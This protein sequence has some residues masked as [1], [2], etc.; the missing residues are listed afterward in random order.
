LQIV[1][2]LLSQ[3]DGNQVVE[4]S[5]DRDETRDE[6]ERKRRYRTGPV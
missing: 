6:V 4:L 1:L 2:V 5:R 3:P